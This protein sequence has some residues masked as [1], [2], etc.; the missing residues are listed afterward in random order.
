MDEKIIK[1][2]A[3]ILSAADNYAAANRHAERAEALIAKIETDLAAKVAA[4][5]TE[6][7]M[8]FAVDDESVAALY[9]LASI[10]RAQIAA[11]GGIGLGLD[12]TASRDASHAGEALGALAAHLADKTRPAIR[13][14]RAGA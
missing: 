1:V 4:A 10:A 13:Y 8:R 9:L 2:G 6:E 12:D 3:D 5:T 11:A 14:E 7:E